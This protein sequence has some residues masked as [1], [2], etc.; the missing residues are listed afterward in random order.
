MME[1]CQCW[2]NPREGVFGSDFWIQLRTE[3]RHGDGVTGI[4]EQQKSRKSDWVIL[5]Q[6]HVTSF[7]AGFRYSGQGGCE[8]HR[9]R[10]WCRDLICPRTFAL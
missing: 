5:G 8:S 7:V 10:C 2:R 1:L 4:P 3:G 6:E 9:H